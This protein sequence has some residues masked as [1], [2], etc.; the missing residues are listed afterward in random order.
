MYV[1]KIRE[2]FERKGF[3]STSQINQTKFN[4]IL[5]SLSVHSP[6]FRTA[7]PMTKMYLRNYGNKPQVGPALSKSTVYVRPL[8]MASASSW[9]NFRKSHV[10]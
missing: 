9:S 8:T 3:N 1:D 10:L 7:S 4:E 5:D 6:L 2:A